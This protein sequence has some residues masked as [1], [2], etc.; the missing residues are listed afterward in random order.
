MKAILVI[1]MPEDCRECPVQ[2]CG[3]CQA[4]DGGKSICDIKIKPDWCPL[5]PAPEKRHTTDDFMEMLFN[6]SRNICIDEFMGNMN[7]PLKVGDYVS[8]DNM[9]DLMANHNFLE[10]KGIITDY[11]FEK[12][13]ERGRWLV[14]KSIGGKE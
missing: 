14:I 10:K 8:F 1:D 4:K 11:V 13:G 2:S 12:D 9:E 5:R 6:I 7:I 3:F